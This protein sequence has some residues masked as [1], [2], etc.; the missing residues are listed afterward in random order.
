M[1]FKCGWLTCVAFR[2]FFKVKAVSRKYQYY[3]RVRVA[4]NKKKT[5]INNNYKI[6]DKTL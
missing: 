6:M 2:L 3:T 1:A 5:F 4:K